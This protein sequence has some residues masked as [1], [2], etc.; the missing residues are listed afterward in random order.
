MM[1][2]CQVC[3]VCCKNVI[4]VNG[5]LM[6]NTECNKIVTE[7]EPSSIVSP[8]SSNKF[9]PTGMPF[10]VGSKVTGKAGTQAVLWF[11]LL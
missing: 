8:D 6:L 7:S 2:A 9:I 3:T 4:H 11:L 1:Y 10:P 5:R